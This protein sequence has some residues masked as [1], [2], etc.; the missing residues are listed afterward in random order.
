MIYTFYIVIGMLVLIQGGFFVQTILVSDILLLAG[1]LFGTGGRKSREYIQNVPRLPAFL[2]AV[3]FL[4]YV[5]SCI[6]HHS[7]EY[8]LER[9]L[10]IFMILLLYLAVNCL[11]CRDRERLL[12]YVICMGICESIIGMLSYIGLLFPFRGVI[13]NARFM[14]TFQYANATALFLG[15][16][17]ILQKIFA[18]SGKSYAVKWHLLTMV[19][20]FLTFSAGAVFCYLI[21]DILL[22]ILANRDKLCLLICDLFELCLAGILAIG[23]YLSKFYLHNHC[24]VMVLIGISVALSCNYDKYIKL[25]SSKTLIAITSALGLA[26]AV[27]GVILFGKRVSGTGIERLCQMRDGMAAVSHHPLLGLG[28]GKWKDY[29]SMQAS[30]QYETSLVHNS[31]IQIGIESG[32][33]AMLICIIFLGY[34]YY[35]LYIRE[36]GVEGILVLFM[37]S[38]H[39][40]FDITFFFGGIMV[41]FMICT[42]YN[43][44]NRRSP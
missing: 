39:W 44:E 19:T 35:S 34:L 30:I 43:G 2:G 32:V 28:T 4:C 3:L 42:S 27:S 25:V 20:M 33:A 6:Y 17:L 5:V 15:I 13:V 31:Y 21:A 26:V 7:D 18:V 11:H 10:Y 23:I 9:C 1:I 16:S 14:G 24:A 29:I 12:K 36:N 40:F 37:V 38:V 22:Y 41:C 8:V